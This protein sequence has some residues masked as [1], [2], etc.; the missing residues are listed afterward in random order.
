MEERTL[1]GR[2]PR[3]PGGLHDVA[4]GVLAWLQPNGELGES[5]AVVIVG[6]GEALLVDTLWTTTLTQ[7]MLDADVMFVGVIPIMWAGPAA[8]WIA[9]IDR[10]LALDPERIVPGHGPVC[11]VAE[12]R[13]VRDYMAWVQEVGTTRLAAGLFAQ[14]AALNAELGGPG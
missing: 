9:A 5:N 10:I 12:A 3:Y 8:N 6:E 7:R 11:G 14:L 4:A 2:G 1:F 13:V